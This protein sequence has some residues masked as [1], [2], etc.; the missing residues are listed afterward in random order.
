M[1]KKGRLFY[2]WVVVGGAG[3]AFFIQSGAA[4]Y[5]FGAFLPL[6]SKETNWTHGQISI[7]F[8]MNMMLAT[9]IAPA[10]GFLVGKYGARKAVVTGNAL[11]AAAFLALVFQSALWQ[12]YAA[13][14]VMGLGAGLAGPV[15]LGTIASNWFVKRVPLAMSIVTGSG[16]LGGL[17]LVP[18]VTILLNS[19][20][21]LQTYMVLF[22]LMLILGAI[23]PGL[24]IR[25]N[26]E[27]IGQLPEQGVSRAHA[28]I[29][30]L[31]SSD[32]TPKEA[33]RTSAFWLLGTF[34]FSMFFPFVF[35]T[36]HQIAYLT[37]LGL[38]SETAAF[39][40][41]LLSGLT[42]LGTAVAGFLS[43]KFPVRMICIAAATTI[44]ISSILALVIKSAPGPIMAVAFSILFGIGFGAGLTSFM[45]LVPFYFGRAHF[46]KIFGSLMFFSI[47]GTTGAPVGGFLFDTTKSY[48]LPLMIVVGVATVSLISIVA[49]SKPVKTKK[50]I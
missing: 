44:L 31:E 30:D 50:I 27:D 41:G 10:V 45:G 23:V 25:N 11:I 5:S 28:G 42:I 29:Q 37:S 18:L 43:L 21:L 8:M 14:A 24:I 33:F 1:S 34:S 46:S 2:G 47:L 49:A 17:V 15:S 38:S 9:L 26:P 7:A 4:V 22:A 32:F 13:Y 19:V 39:T 6:L 48:F 12:F 40:V 36:T 20:G 35:F 3:L 16:G